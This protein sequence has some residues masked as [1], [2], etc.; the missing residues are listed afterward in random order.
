M[1]RDDARFSTRGRG[2]KKVVLVTSK[3]FMK[4]NNG[5]L[6]GNKKPGKYEGKES[7]PV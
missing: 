7:P 5:A 1:G 3:L 2:R 6:S 4:D